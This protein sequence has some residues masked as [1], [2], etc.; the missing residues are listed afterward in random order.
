MS[1]K[2]VINKLPVSTSCGN[3]S[4]KLNSSG[5]VEDLLRNQNEALNVL[6]NLQRKLNIY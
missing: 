5:E 4:K 3:K 2:M 6:L 1:E